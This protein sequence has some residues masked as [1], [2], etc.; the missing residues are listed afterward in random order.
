MAGGFRDPMVGRD[1]L[2]GGLLGLA[3]TAAIY[4]GL[5]LPRW[6]GFASAPANSTHPSTLQGMRPLLAD[7]LGAI[8]VQVVFLSLAVLFVLLLLQL[9]LRRDRLAAGVMWIVVLGIEFLAFASGGPRLYWVTP[10]I[11]ATLSVISVA[12]LCI[13]ATIAFN[14][15]FNLSFFYPL[16]SDTSVWYTSAAFLPV[17]VMLALAIYGF[18]TSLGGQKVFKGG[19]LRE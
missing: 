7:M 16:T 17:V 3:H 13:L 1:L 2:I 14:L 8:V 4:F 5:L 9:I 18:Y 15:F 19:L 11:I 12:R 6:F 10:I